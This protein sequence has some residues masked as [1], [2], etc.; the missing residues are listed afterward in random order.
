[1]KVRERLMRFVGPKLATRMR[2]VVRRQGI[3]FWGNLRRTRPFSENFGFDRG[4]PI[5]RFYLHR[6]LQEHSA[7]IS[8]KVLEIQG[9]GYTRRFG[10]DVTE[11]HSVD[12]VDEFGPTYLC[13]LAHSE[14]VIP[15]NYYDCF[16]LP[17]TLCV[18]RDVETCLAQ[19]LRIVKPRGVILATTSAFVPLCPDCP[20]Y[21]RMSADGWLQLA[22]RVWPGC[23]Y[24][25]AGHGNCLA[26]VAAMLGLAC[27]ELT[28]GELTLHDHRYPV[29]VTLVCRKKDSC[30]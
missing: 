10:Q 29:L 18:L 19:A 8:G 14:N 11:A 30:K 1:M 13:D 25:V 16:L 5:D 3:P 26:A 7:D 17:N 23:E 21:W 22:A 15:S 9:T 4:T 27:E 2:N 20:D 28:D 24:V 6:F 12:I